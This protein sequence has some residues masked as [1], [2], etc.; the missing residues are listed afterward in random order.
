MSIAYNRKDTFLLMVKN[1]GIVNNLDD[2][3]MLEVACQVGN[4]GA[5]PFMLAMSQL[6]KKAF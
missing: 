3:M 4:H 5:E 1:N 2:G 6:L